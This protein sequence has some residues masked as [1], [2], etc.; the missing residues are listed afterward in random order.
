MMSFRSLGRLVVLTALMGVIP[1]VASAQEVQRI[2]AVVNDEVISIYDLSQ[3]IQLVLSSSNVEPTQEQQRRIAPN[4][5]R[6][7]IDERLRVQEAERQNVRVT[8]RDME[9]AIAQLEQ[10]NNIPPGQ[11]DRFIAESGLSRGAVEQQVRAQLIW[12]KFLARR[13]QPT[14]EIGDEEID[15]VLTRISST[16]GQRETRVAEIRL[17]I[18]DPAETAEIRELA[19]NL[20]RQIREGA[21]FGRVANQ[22]SQSASAASGGDIG[23]IQP[24]QLDPELDEILTKLSPG[25]LAGPIETQDGFLILAV[26]EDRISAGSDRNEI[27]VALRQI[28]VPLESEASAKLEATEPTLASIDG[29]PAFAE[30]AAELGVPQPDEPT[31]IRIGDLNERLRDL[32]QN[33][34]V[35]QTSEPL[36]TPAGVQL[37]MIC[38]R[39]DSTG[40]PPRE[41][42]RETLVRE[43]VDM[44]SRRYLRDLRRAAIVDIRI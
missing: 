1:W 12:E 27:E 26:I 18:D 10:N 36:V 3:R 41:T 7:L 32:A 6:R 9:Q 8:D 33:L 16:R 20:V 31:R 37:V 44:L 11:F 29:C 17:P 42:I 34:P 25:Q 40:L 22:F 19:E 15:T 38:D 4:I 13:V 35:G 43:R 2:A 5:L 14:V 28:L 21:S 39:D 23:W 24:G 30:T